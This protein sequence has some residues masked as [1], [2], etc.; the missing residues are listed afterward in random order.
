MTVTIK[1]VARR[2]DVSTATV[3]HVLNKTRFVS[4]ELVGR[5]NL[6]IDELEYY[7][8]LVVGSMR[9][10]KTFTVG[11]VMP[12]ISNETFSALAET[13]QRLL[14]EKQYHVIIC[15][16]AYDET[17]EAATL[18]TLLTKKV[19][20]MIV[21]P[22]TRT[23][24]V[25][26]RIQALGVPVVLVDRVIPDL[27]A[28]TVT[29]NNYLG[30]HQAARFLLELGHRRIG[31]IDRILDH[32]HSLDQKRGYREALAEAGI[33]YD[34][35]LVVRADGFGYDAGNRAVKEL[36]GRLPAPTAVMAFIDIIAIGAM[37]GVVDLGLSVPGDVSLVGFDDMPLAAHTTPRLTTISFPVAEIAGAACE[38]LLKR[39]VAYQAAPPTNRIID[40]SL[41]VRDSTAAPRANRPGE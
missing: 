3:S 9:R 41:H 5:V 17:V 13:I 20:G 30:S 36:L 29:V 11:L 1:D 34:E 22:M 21:I 19:D 26:A 39:L 12:S 23:A 7:P 8:N 10:K 2:A 40:P 15:N 31:Y 33:P 25:Y 14:F 27:A 16:T 6:A 28:D 38:L 24:G 18:R 32:S 37:R 4:D 35:G